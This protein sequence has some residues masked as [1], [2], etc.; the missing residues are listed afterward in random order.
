MPFGAV[1]G[2]LFFGALCLGQGLRLIS[3]PALPV[4]VSGG[5]L[6]LLGLS[7]AVGLLMR[8]SWARWGGIAAALMIVLLAGRMV[9]AGGGSLLDH[10]TVLAGVA[11]LLLLALPATGD[12]RRGLDPEERRGGLLC[13][14]LAFVAAGTVPALGI[15]G[16]LWFSPPSAH[17]DR[18]DAQAAWR[19][20]KGIEWSDFGP[21][22]ERAKAES[23]PILIDFYAQWC[24]PCKTMDRTTFRDK[25][26][27]KLLEDVVAIRVD[28][29][30]TRNRHGYTGEQLAELY[31]VESY[32][33][34]AL[35]DS[36]GRVLE[37][38]RGFRGTPPFLAWLEDALGKAQTQVGSPAF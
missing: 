16:L 37:R 17:A 6:V 29:E 3:F 5:L 19:P 2:A 34:V 23:K 21:G 38:H 24:G 35:L 20:S 28:S 1:F 10:L 36:N 7:L 30:E 27:I 18:G 11:T 26:V 25:R 32:P 4:R 13:T 12:V 15:V 8:R 14:A 31:R 33:T 22:L 9:L